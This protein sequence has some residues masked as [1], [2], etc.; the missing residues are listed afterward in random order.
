MSGGI[1]IRIYHIIPVSHGWSAVL[2]FGTRGGRREL[3]LL[4]HGAGLSLAKI[5][6]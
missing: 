6:F 5:R 1:K 4:R 2:T 3:I